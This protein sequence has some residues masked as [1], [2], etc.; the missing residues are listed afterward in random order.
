MSR[1]KGSVYFDRTLNEFIGIENV[2]NSLKDAYPDKDINVELCKMK[3][4]LL[5]SKGKRRKG[6]LQFI[7][8]WLGNAKNNVTKPERISLDELKLEYLEEIWSKSHHLLVL[9]TK[10]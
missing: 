2:I 5:S 4:W 6:N 9:N 8:N 10:V 7:M 3:V 1:D